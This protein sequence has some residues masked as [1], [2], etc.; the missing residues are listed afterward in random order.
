MW[1]TIL[2]FVQSYTFMA[3]MAVLLAALVGLFFFLRNRQSED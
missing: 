1:Q 2:D 3:I